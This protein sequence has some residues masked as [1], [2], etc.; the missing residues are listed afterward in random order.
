MG[1]DVRLYYALSLSPF[2]FIYGMSV[3][4]EILSLALIQ[5]FLSYLD[6]KKG[7]IFFGLAFLTRYQNLIFLPLLFF[8]KN[9]NKIYLSF[10]ISLVIIIPWLLFNLFHTG[11]AF[12]SLIESYA[13]NIKFRTYALQD[14][15]FLDL[16]KVGNILIPFFIGG[17]IIS[18][19]HLRDK[20]FRKNWTIMILFFVLSLYSYYNTPLKID[21]YLFSLIIPLAYF[22]TLVISKQKMWIYFFVAINLIVTLFLF[23]YA[24]LESKEVYLFPL[25]NLDDSCAL[26]SNYWVPLNYLGYPSEPAPDERLVDRKIEQGYR[27]ILSKEIKEPAYTFDSDFLDNIPVIYEDSEYIILGNES[28]CA[29]NDKLDNTYFDRVD[30]LYNEIYNK[31][32]SITPFEILFTDKQA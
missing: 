2:F 18:F 23:N 26:A 9:L 20:I 22:S 16:V 6:D 11:D 32:F 14:F 17:I 21:R 24:S 1:I 12:T 28:K 4:T 3:G 8:K 5:L 30:L 10:F 13:L 25:D 19:R 15:N 7:G 31:S 29:W 27:V